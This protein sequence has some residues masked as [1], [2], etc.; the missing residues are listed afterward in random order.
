MAGAS[1][2]RARVVLTGSL[3][4]TVGFFVLEFEK[5]KV[6]YYELL[7][8]QLVIDFE[9]RPIYCRCHVWWL[10][11]MCIFLATIPIYHGQNVITHDEADHARVRLGV[12]VLFL[13]I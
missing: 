6:L 11:L 2:E 8:V 12:R 5:R 10:A 9:N 1:Y 7:R 3:L 13:T 4:L